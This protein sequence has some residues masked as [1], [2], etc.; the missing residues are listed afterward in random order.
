MTSP[1]LA[2]LALA[3][4]ALTTACVT[5]QQELA[6]GQEQAVVTAVRRGQF[7]LSCPTAAGTVLSETMLQPI[8]WRG[9]ERAEYTVGVAGC[10]KK[11]TYIVI[12]P[13]DGYGCVAGAARTDAPIR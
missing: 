8:A 10:G 3:A 13:T 5:P 7:E 2:S 9:L 6:Q 11:A 4:V 12:C 1:R